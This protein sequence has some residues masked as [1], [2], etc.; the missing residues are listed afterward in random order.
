MPASKSAIVVLGA[1]ITGLTA[2]WKLSAAYRER[3]ILLEKEPTAGGLAATET[4]NGLSFDIGSHRLHEGYNAEVDHLVKDLCGPDL[5][6]RERHGLIYL[7]DRPI[8]YPPSAL[9]I[10]LAFGA[11]D[12]FRFTRDFLRARLS[13]LIARR[14]P[15]NFE[16]FTVQAVGRSLYERFYRPYAQKLYAVKPH[17][18]ATDPAVSRVRKFHLATILRD[19]K[20]KLRKDR[21]T[22][23]YPARGIGQLAE[24]LQH[25]FTDNGG[26][27][28][29]ASAVDGLEI[30][31]DRFIRA[32]CYHTQEGTTDQ[33]SVELL[34]S[35]IPLDA[36][37][38]L[39]HL[40][41]DG[42]SPPAF[43]LRWRGLRILY[44]ITPDRIADQHETYYFP[45][46]HVPFG[47][48]SELGQYSPQLNTDPDR[49]VLTIEFPCSFGDP[50]WEMSDAELAD[51]CIDV[52]Q[53]LGLARKPARGPQ[54]FFSR[55]FKHV[56]PVYDLRWRERFN[57]IFRRLDSLTNLYMIGR[58]AL[59]LHCNIDHCMAMA[60]ALARHLIE[61]DRLRADWQAISQ[62][63]FHYHIHE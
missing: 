32:I 7:R 61:G 34:I 38:H 13:R 59:F 63:F 14:P 27:L 17:H 20:R 29:R 12:L 23:L 42:P 2:A 6:V 58:P 5:L 40:H 47:R 37:H 62:K 3:V 41:S 9:D 52:L 15:A 21:A 46:A 16:E 45:E 18:L 30:E 39:V 57:Q 55:K 48:V 1:G 22:Y 28:I 25:R 4:R 50:M 51:E 24:T 33:L 10:L 43:D 19:V 60:L 53:R 54:E 36:L 8:P 11:A 49:A 26:R 56:Y 31:D 44:L 35:T